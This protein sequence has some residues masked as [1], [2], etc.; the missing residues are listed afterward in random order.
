MYFKNKITN[1]KIILWLISYYRILISRGCLLGMQYWTFV[2]IVTK[3]N[4]NISADDKYK[5]LINLLSLTINSNPAAYF[6]RGSSMK[7]K[8]GKI[9]VI[10]TGAL[11]LNEKLI[12]PIYGKQT[13]LRTKTNKMYINILP[14]YIQAFLFCQSN[15]GRKSGTERKKKSKYLCIKRTQRVPTLKFQK[16]SSTF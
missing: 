6:I 9:L 7:T 11:K 14:V 15:L 10:F 16:D 2:V 8:Y 5:M 1:L 13:K 3:S 4:L 12:K